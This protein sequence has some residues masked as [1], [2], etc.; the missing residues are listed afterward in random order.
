MT[1]SNDHRRIPATVAILAFLFAVTLL[2]TFAV[3]YLPPFAG[4]VYP[5]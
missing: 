2:V 4:G 1:H 5:G 3:I